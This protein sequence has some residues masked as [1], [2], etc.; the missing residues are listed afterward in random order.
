MIHEK[1]QIGQCY[2]SLDG[3]EL[4]ESNNLIQEMFVKH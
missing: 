2:D 1:E 4:H 3:L